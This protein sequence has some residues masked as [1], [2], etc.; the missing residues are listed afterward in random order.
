[1]DDMDGY[2]RYGRCADV[3]VGTY[4]DKTRRKSCIKRLMKQ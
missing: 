4:N 2:G 3:G 1:M